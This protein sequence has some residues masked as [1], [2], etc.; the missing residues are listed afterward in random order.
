MERL[1]ISGIPDDVKREYTKWCV[2][3]MEGNLSAII[4]AFIHF[5]A[6]IKPSIG[7]VMLMFENAKRKTE[8]E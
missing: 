3:H 2:D 8:D 7:T 1:T 4:K 5:I 6:E